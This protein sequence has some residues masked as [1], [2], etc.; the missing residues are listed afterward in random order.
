ML[1]DVSL[2]IHNAEAVAL[3]GRDGVGKTTLLRTIA[4]LHP[5]TGRSVWLNDERVEKLPAFTRAR[6]VLAYVPQGRGLFSHL[7]VHENLLIGLPAVSGRETAR[8]EIPP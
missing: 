6:S 2:E 1:W 5:I 7:T 8:K 4:G 3:I